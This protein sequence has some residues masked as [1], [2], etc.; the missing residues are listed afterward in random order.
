MP[1]PTLPPG[2]VTV[3]STPTALPPSSLF[4]TML[5]C[6]SLSRVL[7]NGLNFAPLGLIDM[8]NAGGAIEDLKYE[9]SENGGAFVRMEVKGCGRLGVFSSVKPRKCVVDLVEVE[10]EYDL[11]TGLVVARLEGMPEESK[12]VHVVE[13]EYFEVEI[14]TLNNCSL[15]QPG[16][17]P[18]FL[19]QHNKFHCTQSEDLL[20]NKKRACHASQGCLKLTNM[21]F[22]FSTSTTSLASSAGE[23]E[24]SKNIED[25][26]K[27][28]NYNEAL[29][30][31][32]T[33][34]FQ[35]AKETIAWTASQLLIRL[36]SKQT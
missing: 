24:K 25:Q 35:V 20:S 34:I 28:N 4:L 11:E 15:F 5:H 21:C 26:F 29:K 23:F 6:P 17:F 10:F 9:K 2:M 27:M 31:N 36:L 1:P 18:K 22:T 30:R 12:K 7:A 3:P 33:I 8:F 13:V 14:G 32:K 19:V 16:I